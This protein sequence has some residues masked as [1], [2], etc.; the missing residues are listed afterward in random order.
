M[1]GSAVRA[2][3]P[4]AIALAAVAFAVGRVTAPKAPEATAFPSYAEVYERR[5]REYEQ[6]QRGKST[7]ENLR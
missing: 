4:W 1:S 3:L 2:V 5:L 6:R 7:P